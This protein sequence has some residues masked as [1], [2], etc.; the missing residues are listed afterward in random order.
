M[1]VRVGR[2]GRSNHTSLS[3]VM[4]P[5]PP[6]SRS[7]SFREQMEEEVVR[8]RAH[9]EVLLK[10]SS[11]RINEQSSGPAGTKAPLPHARSRP[12]DAGGPRRESTPS[13]L[14]SRSWM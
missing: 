3:R 5:Q 1:R 13:S 6:L 4:A 8:R 11:R 12:A 7:K 9:A 10:L 2:K 14:A